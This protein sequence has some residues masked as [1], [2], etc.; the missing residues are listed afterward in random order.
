MPR[1]TKIRRVEPDVVQPTVEELD[2][3]AAVLVRN[4]AVVAQETSALRAVLLTLQTVATQAVK[5][6]AS[7]LAKAAW[8]TAAEALGVIIKRDRVDEDAWWGR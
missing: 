3:A 1:K 7:P 6:A 8:D 4:A 2:A 5:H